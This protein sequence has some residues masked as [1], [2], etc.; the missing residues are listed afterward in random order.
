[1]TAP[2]R[3]PIPAAL[4]ADPMIANARGLA[5]K[6]RDRPVEDVLDIYVKY[7]DT[8]AVAR[9]F[10]A[11]FAHLPAG[12][13]RGRGVEVGAG[14]AVFSAM[15]AR[16]FPEAEAIHAVEAVPEVVELLQPKVVAA[17]AGERAA[18]VIPVIGSF[19]DIRLPDGTADFAIE[20]GSLHHS[21]DLGRTLAEV[22]R[23]LKPGGWVVALDR[24][25]HD[26][27]SEEQRRFM[28]EVR[29]SPEWLAAN[30]FPPGPLSRRE[31]GE[32]EYRLSEWRAA[33]AAAGFR[34]VKR[35]EMRPVGPRRFL[36]SLVLA[37]PFGL[38]RALGWL[39]SRVREHPGE[40]WWRLRH[41]LGGGRDDAVFHASPN[42]YTVFVLQK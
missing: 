18:R 29:Y 13:F 37:L 39:P 15:V 7:S 32:H 20:V 8:A 27:L 16:R 41:L 10:D 21:H 25:H 38:R 17:V 9:Q 23:V 4:L 12:L 1:V 11:V 22:S 19:D 34:L 24:A 42:E 31:N 28:L 30:G 2:L 36:R 6:Y 14:V 3:W 40:A 5:A 35:F 26:G 33:F